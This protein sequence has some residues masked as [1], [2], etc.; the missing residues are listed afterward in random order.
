MGTF[1]DE[2]NPFSLATLGQDEPSSN[3]LYLKHAAH[4]NKLFQKI[5]SER[6]LKMQT[7]VTFPK[8]RVFYL[9]KM[10]LECCLEKNIDFTSIKNEKACKEIM[11][12]HSGLPELKTFLSGI[13]PPSK[14]Q[15]ILDIS[16]TENK[17]KSLWNYPEG[18][19]A[20]METPDSKFKA[21]QDEVNGIQSWI[22][23][24]KILYESGDKKLLEKFMSVRSDEDKKDSQKLVLRED[25]IFTTLIVSSML[26]ELKN[27]FSLED[28]KKFESMVE[29]NPKWIKELE[30]NF[31]NLFSKTDLSNISF[32]NIS[33][34]KAI[35]PDLSKSFPTIYLSRRLELDPVSK[36]KISALDKLLGSYNR[37]I[38]KSILEEELPVKLFTA[39]NKLLAKSECD[40][41][42]KI[43][44]VNPSLLLFLDEAQTQRMV[45]ANKLHQFFD[46]IGLEKVFSAAGK[47]EYYKKALAFAN[48]NTISSDFAKLL[49]DSSNYLIL[50]DI[51]S[52]TRIATDYKTGRSLTLNQESFRLDG[53]SRIILSIIKLAGNKKGITA[54]GYSRFLLSIAQSGEKIMDKDMTSF[55]YITNIG[56]KL[57]KF[58]L[59]HAEKQPWFDIF[60]K[61]TL[62][63]FLKRKEKFS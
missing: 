12:A 55:L 30:I 44:F 37:T 56:K 27:T 51:N 48:Q 4:A 61:T 42:A 58:V 26:G 15:Q 11:R 2:T 35:L 22:K 47:S 59:E 41:F 21:L 8:E 29:N 54:E 57:P 36:T 24:T 43:F 46:E 63:R 52:Y 49:T 9:V 16:R 38:N 6:A 7:K 33:Y 14:L 1:I 45:F 23:I 5:T 34:V 13:T 60:E 25:K 3:N 10:T 31:Q 28:I 18:F 40:I 62:E 19:K 20:V 53:N 17:I 39:V 32:T 50:K